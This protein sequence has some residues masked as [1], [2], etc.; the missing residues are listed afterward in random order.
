M[1]ADTSL[2]GR[3]RTET[4][5]AIH[6][7]AAQTALAEGLAAATADVIAASAG[8]SRRTFFNYF[9]SK[10]D[11]VLGLRDPVVPDEA[12][13]KFHQARGPLVE[14]AAHLMASILR[15]ALPEGQGLRSMH[16]VARRFPELRGRLKNHLA[17]AQTLA[18]P[19]IL[20]RVAGSPAG[21]G[22]VPL[23]EA[24]SVATALAG[25]IV[26]HA[27]TSDFDAAIAGRPLALDRSAEAFRFITSTSL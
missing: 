2:R 23:E 13:E 22:P 5:A 4:R 25:M 11:A 6:E 1:S 21:N 9:P 16:Q 26:H 12:A 10:E 3:Q 15:S 18:Q 7:A 17:A 20:E 19:L 8:V 14:E 27:Y 24:A